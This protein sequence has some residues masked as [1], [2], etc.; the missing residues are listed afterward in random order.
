[1][2]S[3]VH[4]LLLVTV[5]QISEKCLRIQIVIVVKMWFNWLALKQ[6]KYAPCQCKWII[7]AVSLVMHL[8]AWSTIACS[9]HDNAHAP[10][11]KIQIPILVTQGMSC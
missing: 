9:F 2:I 1:M 5:L 6:N 4:S 11:N 7:E 3:K 10:R 8:Q